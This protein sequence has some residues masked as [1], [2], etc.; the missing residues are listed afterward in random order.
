MSILPKRTL[1]VVALFLGTAGTS[2]A[3]TPEGPSTW[4]KTRHGTL[5]VDGER[6]FPIALTMPPPLGSRTPWGRDAVAEL[7]AAGVNTFRT[8]PLGETWTEQHL[9]SA[10]AWNDKAAEHGV[11]TWLQLRGLAT[12]SASSPRVPLLQRVVE[13]LRDHPGMGLY[14]GWDEPWPRFTP[15]RL[16][17]TYDFVKRNDPNHLYANVFA[18]RSKDRLI[19]AHAPDPPDLRPYRRVTDVA[20]INVYPIYYRNLGVRP[21]K[22]DMVGRW[23]RAIREATGMRA[24]TTSLQ[25]CFAGSDDLGGSGRFI[26]PTFQQ[27]RFMAYDAIVNG[28]RGLVFYGGQNRICHSRADAAL[29]WN[30]T[31]WRRAL[32]RLVHEIGAGSPLHPALVHPETTRRLATGDSG[33]QAISRRIGRVVWIIATN[34]RP[35]S[36]TVTVRGLPTWATSGR[37]YPAGRFFSARDGRVRLE[38]GAW[39]VRVLRFTRPAA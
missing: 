29:G 22:L 7:V 33:A 13:R 30:W 27:E 10:A 18:P 2:G 32:R 35:T 16:A 38:L 31:F 1:L 14:K 8:G 4:T 19:L 21:H 34:R 28:A 20:G 17:F 26:L 3:Q 15:Q 5:L 39:G 37:S 9:T 36:A 6:F 24:V 25:I 11:Y 12:I 23:T